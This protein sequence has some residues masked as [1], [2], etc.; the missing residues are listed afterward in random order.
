MKIHMVRVSD[1]PRK[2]VYQEPCPSPVLLYVS[3]PQWVDLLNVQ[4]MAWHQTLLFQVLSHNLSQFWLIINK[5]HQQCSPSLVVHSGTTDL[6]WRLDTNGLVK[7]YNLTKFTHI[8]SG[9]IY[10]YIVIFLDFSDVWKL[11]LC[12]VQGTNWWFVISP[13]DIV[14]TVD[15][16]YSPFHE[17]SARLC[18]RSLVAMCSQT[19]CPKLRCRVERPQGCPNLGL[20]S[21]KI[22][23]HILGIP[24]NRKSN[25]PKDNQAF[26][27]RYFFYV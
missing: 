23:S 26:I 21:Q 17:I 24:P 1:P 12:P 6:A 15:G 3:R 18:E 27:I 5:D 14:S 2:I 8:V 13:P 25:I 7:Q 22:P 19:F 11:A 20:W 9:L 16:T 10:F 4:V